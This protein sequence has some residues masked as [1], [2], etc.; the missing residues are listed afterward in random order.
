[1]RNPIDKDGFADWCVFAMNVLCG[2]AATS[3]ALFLIY[4]YAVSPEHPYSRAAANKTVK[5][6][7][8][9]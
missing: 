7:L 4:I 9:K 5:M 2:V 1:M 3:M 6:E 8:I